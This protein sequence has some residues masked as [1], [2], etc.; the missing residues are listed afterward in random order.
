MPHNKNKYCH[1]YS[2]NSSFTQHSPISEIDT[3]EQ[4]ERRDWSHIMA[5]VASLQKE[6][7]ARKFPMGSIFDRTSGDNNSCF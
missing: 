7:P 4:Q 5:L 6:L 2:L 3:P 1:L